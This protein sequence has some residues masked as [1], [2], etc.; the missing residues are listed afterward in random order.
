MRNLAWQTSFRQEWWWKLLCR[1]K[2]N[3][4]LFAVLSV[5]SFAGIALNLLKPWPLKIIVDFVLPGK[6][7]PNSLQWIKNL[8]WG[9]SQPATL[10]WLTASTVLVFLL[11]W[12]NM[13]VTR[14]LQSH[15]G[16]QMTYLLAADVFA[17]LQQL[18][19]SFHHRR[20]TGDLVKRVAVDCRCIRDLTLEVCLPAATAIGTLIGV[21]AVLLPL[22]PSLALLALAVIPMLGMATKVYLKRL[23][24]CESDQAE[25]Q[26]AMM[27]QAEQVLAGIPIIQAFGREPMEAT[28]RN[29]HR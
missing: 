15:V 5:L 6:D 12:V 16:G 13:L 1:S 18:S 11:G 21:L 24:D 4:G 28:I 8:P 20:P 10:L 26:S 27:A 7:F 9:G 17:H 25:A 14:Y 29:D 2:A 22:D 19:L 23:M 3:A